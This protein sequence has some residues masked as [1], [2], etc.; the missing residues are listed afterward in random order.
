MIFRRDLVIAEL[1]VI[2]A[3]T[4]PFKETNELQMCQ[5]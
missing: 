1:N 4:T 5:I 3:K 2:T